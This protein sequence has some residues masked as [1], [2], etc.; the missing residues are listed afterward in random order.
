MI[1]NIRL[2]QSVI[3]PLEIDAVKRIMQLGYLG[4][5]PEV[6]RFEKD[7]EKFI[8]G[9][10]KVACVNTG[11]SALHLALQACGIGHGDEVLVLSLIHI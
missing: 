10:S 4:M 6:G 5:G 9:N 8:G 2:S 1:N 11:T 3:G 7:L